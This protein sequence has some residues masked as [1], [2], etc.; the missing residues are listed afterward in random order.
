MAK[1]E[2]VG[3]TVKFDL[4]SGIS[5]EIQE[6]N[7]EAEKVLTNRQNLKSGRWMNKFILK[8]LVSIDG[9]PIPENEGEATALLL[10][11]KTGDR[12]YLILRIR[13][14]SYGDE[15]VFNQECP[16]CKKTAGYQVNL[17]ELLDNGTLKVHP[18]RDDVPVIVETRAGTAEVDYSTGRTELWLAGQKE[19]DTIIL[20]MAACKS[21]NGHPPTY[22][23]F[24]KLYAKDLNKIRMAFNDLKGGLDSRLELDCLECDSSYDVRLY[25]IPDFFIPQTTPESIGL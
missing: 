22:K 17:Q 8:A 5:V 20:G 11:M 2:I 13:M 14:Q 25:D 19:I 1:R 6:I 16:K 15:L 3:D 23:D 18:Y 7:A 9:E 4:P 21:F 12:N 24:S 10:D